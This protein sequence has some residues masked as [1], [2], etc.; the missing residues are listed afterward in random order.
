MSAILEELIGFGGTDKNDKPARNDKSHVNPITPNSE[1]I[2]IAL[3]DAKN[4][5]QEALKNAK[6]ALEEAFT[7]PLSNMM[8]NMTPDPDKPKIR[9]LDETKK[10]IENFKEKTSAYPRYISYDG[11]TVLCVM[12][13]MKPVAR[14]HITNLPSKD[15]ELLVSLVPKDVQ[16]FSVKFDE[17]KDFIFFDF[18]GN[19]TLTLNFFNA[20]AH[21][22][23]E[24]LK[25]VPPTV[26]VVN[27]GD[28]ISVGDKILINKK[29]I[30]AIT[31]QGA[32]KKTE[33]EVPRRQ[34]VAGRNAFEIRTDIL[35]MAIDWSIYSNKN[36]L[37][38]EEITQVAKHFY[39]FVESRR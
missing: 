15:Q 19:N 31:D 22:R 33:D 29:A 35:Q 9:G 32:T 10:L 37:T 20:V 13:S 17:E 28:K 38:P 2:K 3:A 26:T 18:W 27:D 34:P 5:R 36:K 16:Y 14:V 21:P 1:V 6:D 7:N 8:K 23:A 4:V 12:L 24:D 39:S 11:S 25:D 30:Q